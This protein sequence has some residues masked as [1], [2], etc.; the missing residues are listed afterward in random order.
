LLN[1]GLRTFVPAGGVAATLTY[2]TDLVRRRM[3]LQGFKGKKRHF[4]ITP[5]VPADVFGADPVAGCVALLLCCC[6]LR[7]ASLHGHARL[8]HADGENRRDHG[9]VQG[10]GSVLAQGPFRFSRPS[11]CW[12][13]SSCCCAARAVGGIM[14][15]SQLCAWSRSAL[16]VVPSMAIAFM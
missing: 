9:P 15:C 6:R 11:P 1:G 10:H 5:R 14:S 7:S 12:H 16:Q 3:Q 2:P 13:S 8:R 4:E